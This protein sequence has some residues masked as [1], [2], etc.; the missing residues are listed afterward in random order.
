MII[1]RSIYVTP[2][3]RVTRHSSVWAQE[4][5]FDEDELEMQENGM[6]HEYQEIP[7]GDHGSVISSG[8]PDIFDFFA[9]H[10]KSDR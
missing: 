5:R 4:T 8:M 10:T 3:F 6:T 7:D 1:L 2:T 9:T